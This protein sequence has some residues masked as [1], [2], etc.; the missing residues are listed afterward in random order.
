MENGQKEELHPKDKHDIE[1][2][3]EKIRKK[4]TEKENAE[5]MVHGEERPEVSNK[6]IMY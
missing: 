3:L 2:M 4:M 6:I 5:K 1:D